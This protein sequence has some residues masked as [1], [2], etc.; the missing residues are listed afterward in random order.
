MITSQTVRW[1]G[2]NDGQ[3]DSQVDGLGCL[4]VR[5]SGGWACM[6]DSQT[7]GWMGLYD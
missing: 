5:Q 3:S 2:L 6:I 7:V 1:M 4:T